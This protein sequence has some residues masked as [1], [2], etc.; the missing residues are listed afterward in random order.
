MNSRP[1]GAAAQSAG[2]ARPGARAHFAGCDA[3]SSTATA[4]F[5]TNVESHFGRITLTAPD[6]I[7]RTGRDRQVG[8]RKSAAV[9]SPSAPPGVPARVPRQTPVPRSST[10]SAAAQTPQSLRPGRPPGPNTLIAPANRQ[11][12]AAVRYVSARDRAG[13]RYDRRVNVWDDVANVDERDAPPQFSISQRREPSVPRSPPPAYENVPSTAELQETNQEEEDEED[14]DDDEESDESDVPDEFT[15][16]ERI[17][18]EADRV[19]GMSVHM[20]VARSNQRRLEY[21]QRMAP[22][23]APVPE[24]VSAPEVPSAP[25][26]PGA[27]VPPGAPEQ[28]SAPVATSSSSADMSE[29]SSDEHES[30]RP[31]PQWERRTP[32]P[33]SE[34]DES[35]FD[36]SGGDTGEQSADLSASGHRRPLPVPPASQERVVSAREQLQDEDVIRQLGLAMQ[37]HNPLTPSQLT[38][39]GSI[40]GMPLQRGASVRAAR[41]SATPRPRQL[42]LPVV[43]EATR[44]FPPTDPVRSPNSPDSA[45]LSAVP[46]AAP[47][48]PNANPYPAVQQEEQPEITDLEL[49]T[50][51]LDD[52]GY[53]YESA[54]LLTDFLGPAAPTTLLSEQER[55]NIPVGCVEGGPD[56]CS[57]VGVP[58][59]RCGIC[60]SDF[61]QGEM[62][63]ILPCVHMCVGADEIS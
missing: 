5:L 32:R 18:W 29:E 16:L 49:A 48:L 1:S 44:H 22:A 47:A 63:C 61:C 34:S 42:H 55:E 28:G 19:A 58:L 14:E 6:N 11:Q 54:A 17:A 21:E 13:R 3:V 20:R 50:A 24:Q 43:T 4:P 25:V 56:G 23:P 15:R 45:P 51:L 57:I 8:R 52:P 40:R 35:M 33:D 9:L 59:D 27:L 30:V 26:P 39:A 60:L 2:Q 36:D 12:L 46:Q 10:H 41:S 53:Q 7:R 37:S 62:A 38:R 31:L